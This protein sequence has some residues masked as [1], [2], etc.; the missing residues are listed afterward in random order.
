MGKRPDGD[1]YCGPCAA[2]IIVCGRV[3]TIEYAETAG[4]GDCG[5]E[6]EGREVWEAGGCSTERVLENRERMGEKKDFF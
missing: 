5:C 4:T 1:I 6:N 2:D 3:G